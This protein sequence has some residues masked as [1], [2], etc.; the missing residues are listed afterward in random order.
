MTRLLSLAA[1]AITAALL[2][3]PATVEAGGKGKKKDGGLDAAFKKLDTNG[4]GMLSKA[5]F[6]KLHEVMKKKAGAA[7]AKKKP[8]KGGKKLDALFAKLD[9]NHDGF[10]SLEEFK[11]IKDAKKKKDK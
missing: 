8:A 6:A 5:E 3:S 10:L 4:D 9:T 11:K 2:F 7:D 1:C